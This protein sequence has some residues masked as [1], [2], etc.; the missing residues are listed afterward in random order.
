MVERDI[1]CCIIDSYDKSKLLLPTWPLRRCPKRTVYELHQRT[2]VVDSNLN[3]C[4]YLFNRFFGS[5]HLPTNG[6]LCSSYFWPSS[7]GY[8]LRSISYL[9]LLHH[10]RPWCLPLCN[11][12]SNECW[13]Q[14]AV[15]MCH[16]TKECFFGLPHEQGS[17]VWDVRVAKLVATSHVRSWDHFR[18][19]LFEPGHATKDGHKSYLPQHFISIFLY[20][21]GLDQ[22]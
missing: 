1:L 4:C 10:A 19:S 6:Y 13:L 11:W 9:D 21:S 7:L 18:K 15:G 16:L 20:K 14:L 3:R 8:H 22:E 12:W 17:S 2:L 5:P